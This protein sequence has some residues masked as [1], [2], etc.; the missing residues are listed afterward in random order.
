MCTPYSEHDTAVRTEYYVRHSTRG[1][2]APVVN[3]HAGLGSVIHGAQ[4]HV[5]TLQA[6]AIGF[7]QKLVPPTHAARTSTRVAI[8]AITLHV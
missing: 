3:L 8:R 4:E 5:R 6:G 2:L 1:G 7:L